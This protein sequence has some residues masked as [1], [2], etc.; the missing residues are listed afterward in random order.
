MQK[1]I[2]DV[3]TFLGIGI[4][5]ITII[6]AI[7]LDG[8]LSSFFDPASFMIVVLGTVFIIVASFSFND[9]LHSQKKMLEIF[10]YKNE[11]PRSAAISAIELSEYTRKNGLKLLEQRAINGDF[12]D[13]LKRAILM[14]CD[15][16]TALSIDK[17][18]SEEI[19]SNLEKQ[20]RYVS[21]LRKGAEIAP[22]MGLIGTLIG[23]VQ[24]LSHLQDP[25]KIGPSMALAL[26]TTFYGAMLSYVILF[27]LASKLERNAREEMQI[28]RIYLKCVLSIAKSENPRILEEE[29]NSLLSS[30]EQVKYFNN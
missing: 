23:L 20:T 9:F 18:L 5:I 14:V 13:F 25:S 17:L 6:F 11:E 28:S 30:I 21:M 24:M 8:S 29:I 16:K 4:T 12:G 19:I 2:T 26:L 10:F 22:A 7:K 15:A 1:K 27:P 3:S